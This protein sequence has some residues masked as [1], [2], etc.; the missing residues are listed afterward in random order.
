[1]LTPVK[2]PEPLSG[3]D[4]L[5][6]ELVVGSLE[7]FHKTVLKKTQEPLSGHELAKKELDLNSINDE[8]EQFKKSDLKETEMEE[9]NILPDQIT[10]TQEKEKTEHIEELEILV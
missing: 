3:V 4:L 7:T 1:M 2:S 8:V 6:Q 9:R 5:K 10:I